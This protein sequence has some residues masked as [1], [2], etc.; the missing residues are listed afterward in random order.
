MAVR[1]KYLL[2]VGFFFRPNQP[3]IL[4]VSVVGHHVPLEFALRLEA[5]AAAGPA[6]EHFPSGYLGQQVVSIR[7]MLLRPEQFVD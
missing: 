7:R 4:H 2:F 1:N 6:Y 3:R 5:L